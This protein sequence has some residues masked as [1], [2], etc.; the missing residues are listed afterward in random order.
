MHLPCQQ[1]CLDDAWHLPWTYSLCWQE[2]GIK[3]K[4]NNPVCQP[5]PSSST[6]RMNF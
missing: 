4:E 3:E 2:N 5:L 1:G 6:R